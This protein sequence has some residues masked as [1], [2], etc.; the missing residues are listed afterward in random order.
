MFRV[1]LAGGYGTSCEYARRAARSQTPAAVPSSAAQ[2]LKLKLSPRNVVMV[3]FERNIQ[4]SG[5]IQRSTQR[6][7]TLQKPLTRNKNNRTGVNHQF[8]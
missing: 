4:R 5:D 6:Q 8:V 7:A 2:I 1:F 3:K